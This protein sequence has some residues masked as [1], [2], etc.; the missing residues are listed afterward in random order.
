MSPFVAVV[1]AAVNDL[2]ELCV[3]MMIV[4]SVVLLDIG[5]SRG[6]IGHVGHI[7]DGVVVAA[8]ILHGL[9][10]HTVIDITS[11]IVG[12]VIRRIVMARVHSPVVHYIGGSVI[13]RIVMVRVHSP[14]VHY[15]VGSV[16]RRI[17]MAR[18]HSPVVHYIVGSVIAV[19]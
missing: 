3:C 11:D 15:I 14:V 10:M 4:M 8:V 13:R 7:G 19:S 2:V 6:S 17:V 12:S 1:A 16:I 18:V 5:R 9:R